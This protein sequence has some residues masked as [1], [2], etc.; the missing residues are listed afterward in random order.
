MNTPA[1]K[2]GYKDGHKTGVENNPY[3]WSD[4]RRHEYKVGYDAGITRF[5]EE[6]HPEEENQ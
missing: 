6:T 3:E 1:Y 5:C 4:V 2:K